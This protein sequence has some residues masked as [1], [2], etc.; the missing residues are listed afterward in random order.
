M[1]LTT[2][3]RDAQTVIAG[4]RT[5]LY[6]ENEWVDAEGGKTFAVEN[7]ATGE[8]LAQ[9]ADGSPA[10]A[11]RA[12]AAAGAA[13]SDWAKT[14]PRQRSE[15]LRRAY[16]LII[17]RTDDLAAIMTAEMGKPLAEARGEVAYAAEFFRWFSEE[18]VRISGDY[19]T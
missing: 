4:L 12:I 14:P 18:A 19:T 1:T 2:T 15:I 9:V 11:D 10:D 16:D 3:A 6:L 7:P 8:V 13:Q 17:E 5:G